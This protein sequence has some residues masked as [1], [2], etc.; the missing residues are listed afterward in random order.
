[1]KDEYSAFLKEKSYRKTDNLVERER[2]I[3]AAKKKF[4]VNPAIRTANIDSINN[5]VGYIRNR[6]K[7]KNEWCSV[8][9]IA[10]YRIISD[11][12]EIPSMSD[13]IKRYQRKDNWAEW[14]I[15]NLLINGYWA[16]KQNKTLRKRDH[17]PLSLQSE[18][19]NNL[20]SMNATFGKKSLYRG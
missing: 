15:A 11:E 6:Y 3:R 8:T 12:D 9:F 1:M 20:I 7:N 16:K 17:D 18:R 14:R 5:A 13:I 19:R 2:A 4:G 10:A